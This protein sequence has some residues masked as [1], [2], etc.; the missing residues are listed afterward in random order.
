MPLPPSAYPAHPCLDC[1]EPIEHR[2]GR[3][4]QSLRCA[5]CKAEV[6]RARQRKEWSDTGAA[7]RRARGRLSKTLPKPQ[8]KRAENDRPGTN[9]PD[10][11]AACGDLSRLYA[12]PTGD[13]ICIRCFHRFRSADA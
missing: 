12:M 13:A 2:P 10:F 1:G 5:D 9:Q 4:R 11:C 3:G 8:G 7:R 6:R